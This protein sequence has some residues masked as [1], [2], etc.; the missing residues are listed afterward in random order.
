MSVVMPQIRRP[1]LFVRTCGVHKRFRIILGRIR[2]GFACNGVG[3][4]GSGSGDEGGGGRSM[5]W[6]YCS[7]N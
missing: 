4:D 2:S 7:Y 3:G 1:R 6:R 5:T